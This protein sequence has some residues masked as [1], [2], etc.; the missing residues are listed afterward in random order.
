MLGY[1]SEEC[2]CE[3]RMGE[4]AHNNENSDANESIGMPVP[5]PA[6]ADRPRPRDFYTA[7]R[8][9]RTG[10]DRRAAVRVRDTK[11]RRLRQ[12]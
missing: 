5:A 8:V 1:W 9:T 6:A 11:S 3:M 12:T 10:L 2:G 7:A 4:S